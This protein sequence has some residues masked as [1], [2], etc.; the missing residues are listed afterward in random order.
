MHTRYILT[1][2]GGVT[3]Q[4]GLDEYEIGGEERNK[5]KIL[6]IGLAKNDFDEYSSKDT[7]HKIVGL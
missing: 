2:I 1:N 6:R 5:E 3:F 7:F 4:E